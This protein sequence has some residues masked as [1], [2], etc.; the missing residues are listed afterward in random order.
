VKVIYTVSCGEP[1]NV[2][3]TPV[4]AGQVSDIGP[5]WRG[6]ISYRPHLIGVAKLPDSERAGTTR[7]LD[8]NAFAPTTPQQPFGNLGRNAIFGPSFWQLDAGINKSFRIT[9]GS[10]LQFR[11]EFF[12]MLNKTNFRPPVVNWSAANFGTFTQTYQPRQ[13][14]FALKFIF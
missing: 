2:G 12:N 4:A 1:L 9:E 7:Y 11:S 3:W 14:Q 8:R 5:D 13:I 10:S 6:A